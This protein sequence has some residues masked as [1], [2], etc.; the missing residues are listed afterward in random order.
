[1]F[2]QGINKTK[3]A[4]RKNV[5]TRDLSDKP[6]GELIHGLVMQETKRFSFFKQTRCR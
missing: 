3:I 2:K 5:Q 6:T 1:M 4:M